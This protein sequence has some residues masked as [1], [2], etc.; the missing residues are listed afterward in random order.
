MAIFTAGGTALDMSVPSEFSDDGIV[1]AGPAYNHVVV[2]FSD[3]SFQPCFYSLA[4]D[5]GGNISAAGTLFTGFLS[6][7]YS[8]SHRHRSRSR[9]T[10]G[11]PRRT[12]APDSWP[13]FCAATMRSTVRPVTM[14]LCV[15]PETT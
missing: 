11:W 4:F 8:G 2:Q 1:V 7:T 12:T 9:S 10:T 6:E 15:S 5:A 3:G 13:R 14:S